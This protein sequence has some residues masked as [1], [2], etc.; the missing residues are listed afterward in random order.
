MSKKN[1]VIE[2]LKKKKAELEAQIAEIDET[3]RDMG[4]FVPKEPKLDPVYDDENP[5]YIKASAE[6]I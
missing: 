4:E 3:L 5:D 1:V 6:E 2:T